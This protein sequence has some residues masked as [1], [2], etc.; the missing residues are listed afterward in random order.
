[1]QTI[2]LNKPAHECFSDLA[3]T[4]GKIDGNDTVCFGVQDW[5]TEEI[6]Q[7][8]SEIS[9]KKICYQLEVLD[10]KTYYSNSDYVYK[11]KMFDEVWDYS[12]HN[13]DFLE[14]NGIK[15]IYKQVAPSESFKE[16]ELEKEIDVLHFG[17]LNKHRIEYLNFALENDIEIFDITT[18][19][20]R[21]VWSTEIHELIRKSRIVL[22]LHSF[23]ETPIQEAVRYQY[24]LSNNIKVL[25]EKSLS[26]PLNLPEFSSK[27]E[28]AEKLKEL[29]GQNKEQRTKNNDNSVLFSVIMPVY[30][31]EQFLERSISSVLRQTCKNWELLCVDDGSTDN[32]YKKLLKLADNEPRIKV[33]QQENSG[34]A[35]AR[36]LAISK[37]AGNYIIHL[38]ADDWYSDDLL[39]KAA[40]TIEKT[41]ADVI[42]PNLIQ[43]KTNGK[44]WDYFLNGNLVANTILSGQEAFFRSLIWNGIHG[45]YCYKAA[46]AK[47]FCD[48][49]NL[50]NK[51]NAD[52]YITRRLFLN[53]KTVAL[54]A[55]KYFYFLNN[56]SITKQHSA[57]IYGYLQTN[58]KLAELAQNYNQNPSVIA[59]ININS[60]REM[61]DL[62]LIYFKNRK[63]LTAAERKN[64]NKEFAKY[65]SL[66]EKK[67]LIFLLNKKGITQ[68]IQIFTLLKNYTFFKITLFFVHLSQKISQKLYKKLYNKFYPS[69]SKE[70]LNMLDN[71]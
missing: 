22:G 33:F 68:K 16:D 60:L 57:K 2:I 56:E 12:L 7:V 25:A 65:H 64:V 49:E 52:D 59:F 37:A 54:C 8:L 11:L 50:Q 63:T 69:L 48:A 53:V 62:Q 35:Q 36:A 10:G 46:Y 4:V 15:P 34:P 30:N 29:L 13:F 24:P 31:A 51:F 44:I 38:D 61:I 28:M 18:E 23:P 3:K 32:S 70:L 27:K 9:G 6:Q 19:F 26:N 47:I 43:Q 1:M 67:D 20:K 55:G 42:M 41:D 5:N 66:L 71:E 39:E 17:F 40:K 21:D 58:Q 45:I 14:Q